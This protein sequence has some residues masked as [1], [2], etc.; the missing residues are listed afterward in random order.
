MT[1]HPILSEVGACSQAI[2][3]GE[4][5]LIACEQAPTWRT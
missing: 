2:F 1:N 4:K 3:E 5:S